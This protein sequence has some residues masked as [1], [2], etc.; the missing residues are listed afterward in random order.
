MN[1][2]NKQMCNNFLFF[3]YCC[4]SNRTRHCFETNL[5]V[6]SINSW[7][8]APVGSANSFAF[9]RGKTRTKIGITGV[10]H[11]CNSNLNRLPIKMMRS[12]PSSFVL[13]SGS[14]RCSKREMI[15][16]K[17]ELKALLIC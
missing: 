11:V 14:T 8:R 7:V 6:I 15:K 9:S 1:K 10:E 4:Q 3:F 16:V 5:E 13:C 12:H 2:L 17:L